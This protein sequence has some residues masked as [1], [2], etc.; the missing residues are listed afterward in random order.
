MH[1]AVKQP[2]AKNDPPPPPAPHHHHHHRLAQ[3]WSPALCWRGHCPLVWVR[4]VWTHYIDEKQAFGVFQIPSALSPTVSQH[5][6]HL[7]TKWNKNERHSLPEYTSWEFTS[8]VTAFRSPGLQ[9]PAGKAT[10]K[11]VEHS[12]VYLGIIAVSLGMMDGAPH[13]VVVITGCLRS[14]G[15]WSGSCGQQ[16]APPELGQSFQDG[17]TARNEAELGTWSPRQTV[18]LNWWDSEWLAVEILW[19]QNAETVNLPGL[20]SSVCILGSFGICTRVSW[21]YLR[22]WKYYHVLDGTCWRYTLTCT[23]F[24]TRQNFTWRR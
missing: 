2:K 14:I 21:L 16:V 10:E 17:G 20:F 13:L 3:H 8:C 1:I 7:L 19:I 6:Q 15:V 24:F 12:T 22:T 5:P 11:G 4:V 18:K 23:H 9:V